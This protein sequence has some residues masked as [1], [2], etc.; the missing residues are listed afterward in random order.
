[1]KELVHSLTQ[2][3]EAEIIVQE[4]TLEKLNEQQKIIVEYTLDK[5]EENLRD[6][7]QLR[8]EVKKLDDER[9]NLKDRLAGKMGLEGEVSLA[10]ITRTIIHSSMNDAQAKRLAELRETLIEKAREVRSKSKQNMLLIRHAIEVNNE[11][12]TQISGLGTDR[13]ST[14]SQ[15]GR[16]VTSQHSAIVDAEG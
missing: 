4:R 7:D 2:I 16:L 13:V 3:M 14:Y 1:M 11:L 9:L 12:L 8:P 10:E 5:L 15:G 6:L